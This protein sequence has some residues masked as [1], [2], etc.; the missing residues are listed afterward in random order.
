MCFT[1]TVHFLKSLSSSIFAGTVDYA[2][3]RLIFE[4]FCLVSA[5][6]SMPLFRKA[7]LHSTQG[8]VSAPVVTILH[9]SSS[10]FGCAQRIFVV[11]FLRCGERR[12]NTANYFSV[13]ICLVLSFVFSM[14]VLP[15]HRVP[16]PAATVKNGFTLVDK[17]PTSVP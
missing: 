1:T 7:A 5:V 2:P 4:A 13:P 15:V 3:T 16:E 8:T 10:L 6:S 12:T 17:A 9:R 14:K 11:A